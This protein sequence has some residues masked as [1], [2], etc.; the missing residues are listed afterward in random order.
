MRR[1]A[2]ESPRQAAI[3]ASRRREFQRSS[4]CT[5]IFRLAYR[6]QWRHLLQSRTDVNIGHLQQSVARMDAY[7][8]RTNV[9]GF[10][11]GFGIRVYTFPLHL[12]IT[13]KNGLVNIARFK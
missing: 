4:V 12:A 5:T 13:A 8:H 10:P 11:I 9:N 6:A 1:R 7:H 3:G 2:K